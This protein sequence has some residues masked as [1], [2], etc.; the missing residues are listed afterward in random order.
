V[1]V[2]AGHSG[3][4]STPYERF[5]RLIELPPS[6]KLVYRVLEEDAPMTQ[7][8]VRNEALLP[9]RTTRDALMKLKDENL[10]EERLYLPDARKRLYAPLEI[11]RSDD[12]ME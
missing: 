2:F 9:A 12:T 4:N 1:V 3:S 6:A 10:I 8:Q 11:E 7:K 5:E